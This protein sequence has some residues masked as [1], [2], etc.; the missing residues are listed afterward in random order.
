MKHTVLIPETILESARRIHLRFE[1]K[2]HHWAK[3]VENVGIEE[4]GRIKRDHRL[5]DTRDEWRSHIW[6]TE[7]NHRYRLFYEVQDTIV[8]VVQLETHNKQTY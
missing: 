6:V 3:Q 7:L 8:R 4:L 1:K 2:I 5:K